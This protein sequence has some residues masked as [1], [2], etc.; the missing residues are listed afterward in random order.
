MLRKTDIQKE[1][2][3]DREIDRVRNRETVTETERH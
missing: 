1:G 3:G 2:G